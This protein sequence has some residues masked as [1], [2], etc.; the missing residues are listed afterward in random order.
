MKK[1][2]IT[3]FTA[4]AAA[5]AFASSAQAGTIYT[6]DFS[7]DAGDL[8]GTG[9]GWTATTTTGAWQRDAGGLGK[10]TLTGN[11]RFAWLP[12]TPTSGNEYTLSVD[13]GVVPSS[14]MGILFATDSSTPGVAPVDETALFTTDTYAWML[15]DAGGV[16]SFTG[17]GTDGGAY[18]ATGAGLTNLKIVLNTQ[19]STWTAEYIVGGTS[20]RGPVALPVGATTDIRWVGFGN[21]AG[22]GTVDN[23][24]LTEAIPEPSSMSLLALGG[25]ALL[26]RRR[27]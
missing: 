18:T 10:A 17:L 14:W 16:Q 27:A 6:D 12:F 11:R 23:F 7:G 4:I 25:L 24:L 21:D 5:A 26:R 9:P 3:L 22:H 2:N 1:R 20:I 8:S 15:R 19:A 13:M